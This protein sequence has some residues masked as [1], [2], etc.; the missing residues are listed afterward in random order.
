M[1]GIQREAHQ[2]HQRPALGPVLHL[3]DAHCVGQVGKEL[4]EEADYSSE[5]PGA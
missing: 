3:H 5:V 2:P 4:S 1:G